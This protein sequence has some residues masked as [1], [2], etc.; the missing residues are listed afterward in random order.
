MAAFIDRVF[1]GYGEEFFGKAAMD[2][3]TDDQ[4]EEARCFACQGLSDLTKKYGKQENWV[5]KELFCNY[6]FWNFV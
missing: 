5:V 4:V 1:R 3:I 2:L 6:V